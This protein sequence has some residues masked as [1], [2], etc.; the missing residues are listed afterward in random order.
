MI[1]YYSYRAIIV[2]GICYF[3]MSALFSIVRLVGFKLYTVNTIIA[4]FTN[5]VTAEDQLD[6][7]KL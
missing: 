4:W 5:N 6:V 7:L 2:H 1:F 3:V